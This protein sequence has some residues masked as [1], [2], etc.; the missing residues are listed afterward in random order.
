MGELL[1]SPLYKLDERLPIK[2]HA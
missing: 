1:L 2:K